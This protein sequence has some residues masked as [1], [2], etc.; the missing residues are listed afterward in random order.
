MNVWL[1]IVILGII[2]GITEFLP[3]SSTGHLLI[4]EQFLPQRGDTF[5]IV[6]QS[7]AVA[8]VLFIY[9]E[10]LR[11]LITGW[12][13]PVHRDYL[14]KL[15]AAFVVTGVGGLVLKAVDFE[16]PDAAVPVGIA[17]L[18]GGILFLVLE[19]WLPGRPV[20]LRVTW[21]MAMAMAIAQLVAAVF[22]GTSRAGATIFIAL[23]MGLSRPVAVE[24]SFLLGVPTLMAAGALKLLTHGSDPASAP[25]HYGYLALGSLVS[26]VTAFIAVRWLLA[27]LKTHTF[28]GFGWYRII[29]GIAVLWLLR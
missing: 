26:A 27:F 12:R 4:A 23:V 16:L 17:T 29:L 24:F 20:A 7:A 18:V 19:R 1:S 25:L 6:I 13:E 22:P 11:V 10:R 5:L 9:R 15:I 21:T 8:S 14:G 28:E 3:I 2:E